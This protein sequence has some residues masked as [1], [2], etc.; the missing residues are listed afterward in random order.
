MEEDRERRKNNEERRNQ[1]EGGRKKKIATHRNQFEPTRKLQ[2]QTISYRNLQETY[3][4]ATDT[5]GNL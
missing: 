2:K 3:K 4:K 1:E 5:Y